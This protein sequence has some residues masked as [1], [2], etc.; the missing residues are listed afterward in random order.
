[1]E[2]KQ[3]TIPQ[4]NSL[5]LFFRLIAEQLNDAGLDIRAVLEPTVDIAWNENLVKELLWRPI[6]KLQLQKH[7]TTELTTRDIDVIY[8]TLNLFL[9]K[10]GVHVPFPSMESL[11]LKD[12]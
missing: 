12:L 3:R 8:D 7:S 9:S 2:E 6:Q 10:H 4:N 5:H 11:S 1:M